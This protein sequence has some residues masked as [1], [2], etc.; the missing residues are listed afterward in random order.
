MQKLLTFPLSTCQD[1]NKYLDDGWT[2]VS[3]TLRIVEDPKI[4]SVSASEKRLAMTKQ[5]LVLV[6]KD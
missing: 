2:V 3:D 5:I 6:Q 4:V 1:L